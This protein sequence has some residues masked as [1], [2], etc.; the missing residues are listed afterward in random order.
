[1]RHR[2]LDCGGGGGLGQGGGVGCERGD[3]RGEVGIGPEQAIDGGEAGQGLALVHG[4]GRVLDEVRQ[5]GAEVVQLIGE[6]GVAEL[7]RRGGRG[8]R[9]RRRRGRRRSPE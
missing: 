2:A 8:R 4:A 9:S 5:G 3:E 1:M 6:V 7:S